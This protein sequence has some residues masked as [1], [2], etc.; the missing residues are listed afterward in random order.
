MIPRHLAAI[1]L[2]VTAVPSCAPKPPVG[3]ARGGIV[4]WFAT[5]K[6]Q[7]ADAANAHCATYGKAGR[8][9]RTESDKSGGHA[10]FICE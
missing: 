7:V 10:V 3:D 4:D 6:G 8:I 9:T 1:T 5:T 2:L